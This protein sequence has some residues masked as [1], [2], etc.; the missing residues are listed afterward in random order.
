MRLTCCLLP[1][2]VAYG[3]S[4]HDGTQLLIRSLSMNISVSLDETGNTVSQ[5]ARD[6]DGY[7]VYS[8]ESLQDARLS[9]PCTAAL[10]GLIRC[11]TYTQ[12]FQNPSYRGSLNATLAES[13]CD[14]GCGISLQNWFASVSHSC[15]GQLLDGVSSTKVGGFIWAGYNE[16]CLK[17]PK[18]GLYCN[19]KYARALYLVKTRDS[20]S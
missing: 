10:S 19:G 7:R 20:S 17:D 16:T 9:A 11:D 8:S 3:F 2:F 5:L 14:S 12:N 6:F 4:K 15:Q 1:L 18:T 13:V